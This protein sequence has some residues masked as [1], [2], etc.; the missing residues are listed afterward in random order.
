MRHKKFMWING[1]DHPQ[2]EPVSPEM[3]DV[4]LGVNETEQ[5]DVINK[6]LESIRDKEIE[7]ALM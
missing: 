5:T 7:F 1:S 2:M 3:Y 4:M 6:K